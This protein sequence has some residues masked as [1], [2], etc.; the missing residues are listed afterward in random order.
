MIVYDAEN[1]KTLNVWSIDT[2]MPEATPEQINDS[3]IKT[4]KSLKMQENARRIDSLI[5]KALIMDI[6]FLRWREKLLLI[7][8]EYK[9]MGM[10]ERR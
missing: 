10:Y 8:K 9:N 4:Q 7:K 3:I 5:L 1:D 2:G 6:D